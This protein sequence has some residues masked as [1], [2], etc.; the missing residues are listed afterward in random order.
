VTTLTV[1]EVSA[2]HEAPAS[3]FVRC[4]PPPPVSLRPELVGVLR[5]LQ[6]ASHQRHLSAAQRHAK[7]CARGDEV[8]GGH[9]ATRRHEHV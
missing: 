9:D 6:P 2:L 4:S 1:T 5:N 7:Q 3:A 8:C